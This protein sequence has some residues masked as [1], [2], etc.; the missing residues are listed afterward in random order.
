MIDS[1]QE[2]NS[3]ITPRAKPIVIGIYGLPGSGKSYLLS[4]LR[5]Y[6]KLPE[7]VFK[8]TPQDQVSV[9]AGHFMFWPEENESGD[10]VW[11]ASDLEV[12]THIIYMSVPAEIIAERRQNDTR[13]S[14]TPT[15]AEHLQR[16]QDIEQ[17]M[18]KAL[19]RESGIA[20]SVL[21]S[22]SNLV[23]DCAQQLCNFRL[24]TEIHN[25]KHAEDRLDEIFGPNR[26]KL[27]TVLVIDGDKTLT[28]MDTGVMFWEKVGKANN[29]KW[30]I[31]SSDPLKTLFGGP[32][33]YS[34]AAFHQASLLYEALPKDDF[35]VVCDKVASEVVMYSDFV[36]LLQLVSEQEHVGVVI[37]S[38]RIRRVWEQVLAR[39]NLSA[40][41]VVAAGRLE[42]YLV[43]TASVKAA[44]VDRLRKHYDTHVWAF[45]DS[46]LD[47]EMLS[48]A[49]EAIVIVGEEQ[50]RS[51]TMD[52]MLMSA[53]EHKNLRAR[54]AVLPSTASPR[55]DTTRMPLVQLT[56]Q[57]FIESILRCRKSNVYTELSVLQATDRIAAKL[58]MTPMRNAN[59]SGHI[60]REAHHRVG[61]YLAT[62]FLG[63]VLG[64]EEYLVPHVQGH[65]TSGFR[66][67]HEHQTLIVALMRGGEPM[68]FGVSEALPL[69]TFL[70]AK[71]PEDIKATHVKGQL[72]I[73]LV[74]SVVNSGKTIVEF[75]E[76]IRKLH[77]TIRIVVVAGVVQSQ[78]IHG[79][80]AAKTLARSGNFSIVALRLSE[81]KFTG[82]GTTDTGN[83]LFNTIYLP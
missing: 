8:S 15:S 67:L 56:S 3:F 66:V 71:D 10:Q 82:K 24:H 75:V 34:Y 70:H 76:H 14:R 44:L 47:L 51:R 58:L 80:S 7:N 6:P 53:I 30:A 33:G 52:T 79:S 36:S 1:A 41:K 45:G 37:V 32:L 61:Y 77:A 78:A 43:V 55:L 18:L 46:P 22:T 63:N 68:A 12:Y 73:V 59:I 81:N 49:D 64:I 40:V 69:A 13:L 39:E 48:R 74:D 35:D 50:S 23:A 11:T 38:C 20:F 25:L 5:R 9:V 65:T 27:E 57:S 19:C 17:N 54:Q 29:P 62:E 26:E 83:R 31:D 28:S 2:E 16:W 4:H 60:L 21:A 42:D 72:N